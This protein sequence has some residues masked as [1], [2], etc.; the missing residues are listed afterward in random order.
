MCSMSMRSPVQ[1]I[2]CS[3]FYVFNSAESNQRFQIGSLSR[4]IKQLSHPL[5]QAYKYDLKCVEGKFK[6]NT[7][8]YWKG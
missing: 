4:T 1:Y 7:K 2:M 3:M 8:K 5:L 6:P